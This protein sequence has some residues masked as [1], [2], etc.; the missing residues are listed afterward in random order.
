M[1]LPRKNQY[2]GE[3]PPDP[4][5]ELEYRQEFDG[6]ERPAQL[7]NTCGLRAGSKCAKCEVIFCYTKYVF[8]K[9]CKTIHTHQFRRGTVPKITRSSTGV[10][11][12]R[13]IVEQNRRKKKR[14]KRKTNVIFLVVCS[15]S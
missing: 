2:H 7:C 9:I 8:K 15:V 5:V 10:P 12:T 11:G 4:L 14:K 6:G 3:S 13:N 1:Q